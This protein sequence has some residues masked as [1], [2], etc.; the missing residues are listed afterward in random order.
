MLQSKNL[1]ADINNPNNPL[2]KERP[3]NKDIDKIGQ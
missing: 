2:Y 1:K 3:E